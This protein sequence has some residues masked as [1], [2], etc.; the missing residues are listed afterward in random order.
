MQRF[1]HII[2]NYFLR[3]KLVTAA[4]LE[5]DEDE[6]EE[7]PKFPTW[8]HVLRPGTL[9]SAYEVDSSNRSNQET[10]SQNCDFGR[11]EDLVQTLSSQFE[12]LSNAVKDI[13]RALNMESRSTCALNLNN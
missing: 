7:D 13:S 3:H 12:D 9:E 5:E 10:G 1:L 8:L 11:I 4:G 6:D 2:I